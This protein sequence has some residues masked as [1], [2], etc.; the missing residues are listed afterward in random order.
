ME[1]TLLNSGGMRF[2]FLSLIL[3]ATTAAYAGPQQPRAPGD[4][5][6]REGHA[7]ADPGP[8]APP[9]QG[10]IAAPKV[11][12]GPK[13]VTAP[14]ETPKPTI[15]QGAIR[16]QPPASQAK[17][18]PPPD[19]PP[20][21]NAF[22]PTGTRWDSG[23]GSDGGKFE[24]SGKCGPGSDLWAAAG[25]VMDPERNVIPPN[26]RY[27]RGAGGW[28]K[29]VQDKNENLKCDFGPGK[30]SMCTSATAAAFCQH[31]VDLHN[32]RNF[33]L[34]SEELG[35]LCDK[36]GP[37]HAALNGNTNSVAYLFQLLGGESMHAEGGSQISSLLLSQAKT[38]DVLRLDR[39]NGT[40]HSTIFQKFE[41]GKVCYWSSNTRTNGVGL[42]CE[43]LS[44]LKGVVVSR[45]PSNVTDFPNKV[46]EAMREMKGFSSTEANKMSTNDPKIKW[47]SSMK[48]GESS[49][50]QSTPGGPGTLANY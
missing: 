26:S 48:C 19:L 37:A 32:G 6:V 22:G 44:V 21:S 27:N 14:K 10:A 33:S 1:S 18:S 3:A 31:I 12:G 41:N 9:G 4:T 43:S 7:S 16:Q 46:R 2:L 5:A 11:Y 34:T 40:G 50:N 47:A 8:K 38:G 23:Q 28:P 13:A 25:H 30:E 42:Q 35:F 17:P 24:G 20:L 39:N 45:F 49:P 15:Y 29:I 36:G